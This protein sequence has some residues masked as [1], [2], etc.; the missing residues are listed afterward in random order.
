MSNSQTASRAPILEGVVLSTKMN[1]TIIVKIE[2]RVKHPFYG[3]IVKKQ[4]KLAV[5]DE[6]NKCI[7]GDMVRIQECRPLSKTKSWALLEVLEK[8]R[9]AVIE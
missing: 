2:R 6:Q 3:K 5:H 7:E 9:Q 1:K 4:T 8:A